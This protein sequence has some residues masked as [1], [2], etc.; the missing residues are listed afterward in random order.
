MSF[1]IVFNNTVTTHSRRDEAMRAFGQ[2]VG[3]HA[4]ARMFAVA[5][6]GRS[7]TEITPAVLDTEV[8]YA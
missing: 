6:G 2:V 4:G 3:R 1:A 8:A 5:G 7:F